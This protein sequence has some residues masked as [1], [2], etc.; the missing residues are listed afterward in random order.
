[1]SRIT[2]RRKN[3]KHVQSVQSTPRP[4][5]NRR[6]L[7]RQPVIHRE[8]HRNNLQSCIIRKHTGNR[9]H[10]PVVNIETTRKRDSADNITKSTRIIKKHQPH[11]P[12]RPHTHPPR[13]PRQPACNLAQNAS[14]R[15]RCIPTKPTRRTLHRNTH[16]PTF[17]HGFNTPGNSH[18]RIIA[19]IFPNRHLQKNNQ[20]NQRK[21]LIVQKTIVTLHSQIH[22]SV[23]SPTPPANKEKQWFASSTE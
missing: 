22:D 12:P 2:R 14:P 5:D 9:H 23:A 11:T 1:M 18:P 15:H 7:L 19:Q 21:T 8:S 20:K 17:S 3:N 6:R 10:R 4:R 16:H 13:S